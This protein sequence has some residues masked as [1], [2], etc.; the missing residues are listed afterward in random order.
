VRLEPSRLHR[1]ERGL[2][3]VEYVL[4]LALLCVSAC[5]A[6]CTCALL[7]VRLFA[8]QQAVLLLPFP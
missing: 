3:F 5:L 8:F 4:A 7:L 2:V 6:I 1:D